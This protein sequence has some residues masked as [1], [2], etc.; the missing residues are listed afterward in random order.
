M[1]DVDTFLTTLYIMV[2]DFCKASWLSEQHPGPQA[3][4]SRSA[5]VTLA[6]FGQWQGFGSARGFYRYAHRPWRA[7]LPTL[8]SR[9]QCKR[10]V[11]QHYE[12]LVACFLH[13]VQGLAARR[14]PYEAL[15]S[16]GIPPRD[17]KRRGV[18]WL[19]AW[20]IWAGATGWAGT[21]AFICSGRSTPWGGSPAAVWG[22]RVRR[23]TPGRRR[24]LPCAALPTRAW[25]AAVPRP[26]GRMV[27]RRAS[28]GTPTSTPGGKPMAPKSSV[29]RS[30][31]A[32]HLGPSGSG[33]GGR[34]YA[35]SWRPW[36]RSSGRRSVSIVNGLMPSAGFR[37]AW[38]RRWPCITSVYG[39]RSSVAERYSSFIQAI[40]VSCG[41]SNPLGAI[42]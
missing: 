27:S 10:H 7:A 31:I 18:G 5:V 38:R 24:A 19:P 23:I 14:C 35:R 34:G 36:M 20:P 21:R 22:R 26:V 42:R 33:A 3:T 17:A 40:S 32:E 28:R 11:R 13:L 16:S 30:A 8:P 12:A 39:L 41:G 29:P 2:D 6:L 15:D 37:C 25:R 1:V 9:E 4:L